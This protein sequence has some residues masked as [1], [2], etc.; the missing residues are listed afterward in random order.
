[1]EEERALLLHLRRLC[2]EEHENPD[3][4]KA[5]LDCLLDCLSRIDVKAQYDGRFLTLETISALIERGIFSQVVLNK[6]YTAVVL[7]YPDR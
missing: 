7:E 3:L 6:D 2:R 1:V 4:V 5:R